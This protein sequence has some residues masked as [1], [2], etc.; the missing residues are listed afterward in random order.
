MNETVSV[1]IPFYM[2]FDLIGRAVDSVLAQEL[3]SG[4]QL[5]VI[6]GN[7]SGCDEERLRSALPSDA[8]SITRIARNQRA[9]GA[10][11]ARNAA[12]SVAS[13]DILAFLDADDYWLKGKLGRQLQLIQRGAN[14]VACAYRFEGK[15]ARVIPPANVRSTIDI[16][17][18][19]VGTSTI[20]VT[21]ELL[22]PDRFSNLQYSQDL[23]LW[24]RLTG[25]PGLRYAR[26]VEEQVVYCPS[27]RTAR[28][29][30]QFFRFRAVV[31]MFD[32]GGVMRLV[33]YCQFALRGIRNHYLR[34]VFARR[35]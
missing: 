22:G 5:E 17:R 25:K 21:R 33:I 1:I 18:G 7:D 4:M 12:L 19:T 10:G 30:R 14:F 31:R 26:I 9:H 29:L 34:R 11:N 8:D 35:V 3:P 23:E 15:D 24:C 28:K 2:E 20:A 13:G 27:A 32:I 16:L 6:I